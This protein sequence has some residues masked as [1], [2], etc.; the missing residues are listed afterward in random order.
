MADRGP[1][2]NS[3]IRANVLRERSQGSQEIENPLDA[4]LQE[5]LSFRRA[6]GLLSGLTGCSLKGAARALLTSAA[7]LEVAPGI[8]A[9]RFFRFMTVGDEDCAEGLALG[10]AAMS[11]DIGSIL[12][13]ESRDALEAATLLRSAYGRDR[14]A[15]AR[16]IERVQVASPLDAVEAVTRELSVALGASAVS[17][18]VA[19]LSG[20][21]LVR[22]AQ[23]RSKD[24]LSARKGSSGDARSLDIDQPNTKISL[25]EE[26]TGRAL[27]SQTIQVLPPRDSEGGGPGAKQWRVLAPIT[28]R[29]EVIGLLEMMLASEPDPGM[30]SDIGR[31][32]H[33]LGLV[34]ISDR[35]HTDLFEIGQRSTAFTLPAEIQ[36]R[37]LPPSFTLEANSFTLSGWLEP[38]ANIGGDTFDYSLS[39]EALHLSITDA[40]GHGIASALTATL[41]VGSLRNSRRVSL[42]LAEQATSA[43]EA[44]IDHAERTASEGFVTGVL[45]RLDLR[46][47]GLALLNAG[48]VAPY[49]ARGG[50]VRKIGL[51]RGL[52]LGLF[53]EAQYR[54]AEVPLEKGDRL[55]LVTDGMLER[56]AARLDLTGAI[57]R[58][59]DMHPREATRFLADS[60]LDATGRIIV[61]D[62]TLLVLDWHGAEAPSRVLPS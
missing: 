54:S 26:A 1:G 31:T 5:R 22:L 60:V 2:S 49:I 51:P 42:S 29:G 36:R 10:L 38:A 32:A 15:L 59:R 37:L 39:R 7:Y 3:E 33:L 14:G 52:P 25:D 50:N 6:Q 21:G 9:D 18:L 8:I 35:R 43:N 57:Q 62:A 30:V 16:A 45:G 34:V 27:R 11:P 47:G 17:F 28:E 61:D 23:V 56:K 53:S 20:R 19:D 12:P 40:M 24:G 55:V 58:S 13:A 48:H 44:L 41:C 46:T 4:S